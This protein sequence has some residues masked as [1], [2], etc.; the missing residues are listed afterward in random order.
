MG[1]KC[2]CAWDQIVSSGSNRRRGNRN[3]QKRVA[4]A[5]LRQRRNF[6]QREPINL[7]A[8][9][10]KPFFK[11]C[12]RKI[13]VIKI[14]KSKSG[15]VLSCALDLLEIITLVGGDPESP[16]AFEGVVD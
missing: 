16:V 10:A 5:W 13:D 12:R 4:G 1:A 8:L 7:C 3:R 14:D 2:P 15:M 9:C 6:P 11:L